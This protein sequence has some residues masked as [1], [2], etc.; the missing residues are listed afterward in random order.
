MRHVLGQHP[1]D[2]PAHGDRLAELLAVVSHAGPAAVPA[3]T[4]PS[5]VDL[6]REPPIRPRE[7]EAPLASRVEPVLFDWALK[8][9]GLALHGER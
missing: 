5:T 6:E 2:T 8:A 4:E 3:A 7:V 1:E 9:G